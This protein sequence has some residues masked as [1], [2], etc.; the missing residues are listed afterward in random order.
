MSSEDLKMKW[1]QQLDAWP[2]KEVENRG[3]SLTIRA[4]NRDELM[5]I[6]D[7]TTAERECAMV[8]LSIVEPFTVTP[9]EV[10]GLREGSMPLDL[11]ELTRE[12][13]KLSGLDRPPKEAQKT[14]YK[15]VRDES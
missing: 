6:Q 7:L 3:V 15:S 2:T 5:K 9:K 13:S 11:E 12:I 14:A 8:S 1:L 10:Q 4:I